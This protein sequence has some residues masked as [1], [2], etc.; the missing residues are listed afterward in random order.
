MYTIRSYTKKDFPLLKEWYATLKQNTPTEEMFPLETTFILEMKE[1]PAI[2]LSVILTNCKEFA[3]IENFIAD[4]NVKNRKQATQSMFDAA[5][6]F[7]KALGY[8]R[9]AGFCHEP[10]L[11]ER[12]KEMGM[13]HVYPNRYF[14]SKEVD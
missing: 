12:Y 8:K 10:K 6:G 2:C 3:Y 11:V 1:T 4:P 5:V 14:L 13:T 9:V 7:A